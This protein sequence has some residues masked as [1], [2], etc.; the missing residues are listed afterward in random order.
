[1][2][3]VV[4]QANGNNEGEE[5]DSAQAEVKSGDQPAE[6]Q[7]NLK[8]MNQAELLRTISDFALEGNKSMVLDNSSRLFILQ[9]FTEKNLDNINNMLLD[10]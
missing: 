3:R 1:M 6:A 9:A 10:V 5:P 8:S 4:S 7:M 2:E